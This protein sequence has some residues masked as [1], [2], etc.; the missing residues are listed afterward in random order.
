M[1]D[2]LWAQVAVLVGLLVSILSLVLVPLLVARLPADYFREPAPPP[3]PWSTGSPLRRVLLVVGRNLLGGLLVLA[4][5]AMLLLPGQGLLTLTAGL[6]LL[7][8]PGKRRA[9]RALVRSQR[10]RRALDW[11][12]RRAGEG[13]LDPPRD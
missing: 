7:E 8:F 12:R 5:L 11:V 3:P 2:S 13:P 10:V 4:G 1:P 6:I 9:E